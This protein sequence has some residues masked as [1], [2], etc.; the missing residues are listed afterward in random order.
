MISKASGKYL[1]VS[2]RKARPVADLVRGKNVEEAINILKF[3]PKKAS[4]M[5]ASVIKS[6]VANAEENNE[7]RDV[8]KLKVSKIT[9]DSGPFLKR[10]T[11]RAYGRATPIKRKTSHITVVLGE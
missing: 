7:Y 10:Y 3:S 6:A 9:I 5:I 1:R 2:P 4:K 11:P 8:S